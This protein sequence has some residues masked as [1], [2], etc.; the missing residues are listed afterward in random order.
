[1]GGNFLNIAKVIYD[2]L[3]KKY[4]TVKNVITTIKKIKT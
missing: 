4:H 2:K 3:T 1:M